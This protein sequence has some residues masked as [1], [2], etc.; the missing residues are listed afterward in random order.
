M[1]LKREAVLGVGNMF[2]G[3]IVVCLSFSLFVSAVRVGLFVQFFPIAS[4][5]CFALVSYATTSGVTISSDKHWPP[6]QRCSGG[7]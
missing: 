3:L 1:Q 4:D 5:S 7:L 2:V 6:G